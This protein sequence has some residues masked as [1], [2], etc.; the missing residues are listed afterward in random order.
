MQKNTSS[1]VSYLVLYTF[2]LFFIIVVGGSIL[3]CSLMLIWLSRQ[4]QWS[5]T[6]IASITTAIVLF[7]VFSYTLIAIKYSLTKTYLWLY[8]K[9]LKK[10]VPPF[11]EHLTDLIFERKEQLQSDIANQLKK[12]AANSTDIE[13]KAFAWLNA[14]IYALPMPIAQVVV[15]FLK[16]TPIK[17]WV[18]F[19]DTNWMKTIKTREA[20]LLNLEQKIDAF[21]CNVVGTAFPLWT[22]LLLPINIILVFYFLFS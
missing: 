12:Q 6:Q 14:K 2:V 7:S 22:K 4:N 10:W 17:S 20:L 19:I 8:N 9:L 5:N 16:L 13:D 1:Q 11:A 21:M 15:F 3:N 18:L